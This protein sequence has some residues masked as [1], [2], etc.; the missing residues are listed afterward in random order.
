[1]V[2]ESALVQSPIFPDVEVGGCELLA[3]AVDDTI[4]AHVVLERVRARDEVVL[5][6]LEVEHQPACLIGIAAFELEAGIT[7]DRMA[8]SQWSTMIADGAA[9]ASPDIPSLVRNGWTY[10][11]DQVAI[12]PV[13]AIPANASSVAVWAYAEAID[14]D[15]SPVTRPGIFDLQAGLTFSRPSG[16]LRIDELFDFPVEDAGRVRVSLQVDGATTRWGE[17]VY[18]VGSTDALGRWDWRGGVALSPTSYP[19][20]TGSIDLPEG[21]TVE[22]KFVKVDERGQLTWEAGRNRILSVSAGAS[23]YRGTWR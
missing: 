6:V 19:S 9:G 20:W 1:V 18:A 13:F 7:F 12:S 5:A 17:N 8:T 2:I 14:I 10:F 3:V 4:E 16:R 23:A 11:D 15:A 22:L 21:A